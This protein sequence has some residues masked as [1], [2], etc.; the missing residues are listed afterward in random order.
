MGCHCLGPHPVL[1][2]MTL[3]PV[4]PGNLRDRHNIRQ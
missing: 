4:F 2:D 1:D 3:A